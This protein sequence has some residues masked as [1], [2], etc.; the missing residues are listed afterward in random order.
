MSDE[1]QTTTE[2]ETQK[3]PLKEEISEQTP[4]EK[5]TLTKKEAT[6][7]A[8]TRLDP[9][10]KWTYIILATIVLLLIW[11][12]ISDRLAPSTSQA[13]VHALVVPIAAEVSG[14]VISV[15]VKNNQRITAGQELFQI[16]PER[17]QLAVETAEAD[18]QTAR[19]SMGASTASVKAA[20]ASLISAQALLVRAE[21]D[22]IRLKRIHKE[23]SGAIS[24]RRIESAE[25]TFASARA[26]VKAAKANIEKAEQDLGE[27]GEQNSRILQAQSALAQTRLNLARTTVLAPEDGLVTDVRVNKGNYAN[28]SSPQMTFI[29]VDNIWIQADFTENNL[30]NIRRGKKVKIVFDVLPGQIFTGSVREMGFGVAIDSAP[31]GSLPTIDNNQSWLRAAQR[32][33]VLIDFKLKPQDSAK[34]RVGSQATVVVYT[35]SNPVVNM[36]ASFQL[37]VKSILTYAY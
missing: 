13:R 10:K 25:A 23:D 11:Y 8:K 33:P 26:Q 3:K 34:I 4:A 21:K 20:E 36:L 30:G 29:A 1:K 14:T 31:L 7:A 2:S 37:W 32:Y 35:S 12:L 19:Q 17:Y 27:T 6:K 15:A 22:A 16:D 18:M 9:V 24:Q 5:T 28:A